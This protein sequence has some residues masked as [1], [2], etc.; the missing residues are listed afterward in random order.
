M[1]V[2]A[3]SIIAVCTAV[4]ILLCGVYMGIVP[5]PRIQLP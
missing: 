1:T 2:T 4:L 5:L 3:V